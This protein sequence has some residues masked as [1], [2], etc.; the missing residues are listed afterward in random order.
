MGCTNYPVL[1]EGFCFCRVYWGLTRRIGPARIPLQPLRKPARTT[2]SCVCRPGSP[3]CPRSIPGF[4]EKSPVFHTNYSQ[5]CSYAKNYGRSGGVFPTYEHSLICTRF[6]YHLGG[7]FA[8]SRGVLPIYLPYYRVIL[9]CGCEVNLKQCFSP[10]EEV[11]CSSGMS[12]PDAGQNGRKSRFVDADGAFL[13]PYP[14][15]PG[16]AP[17]KPS[18]AATV[19]WDRPIPTQ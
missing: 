7:L 12:D 5:T 19:G 18:Q 8:S 15:K 2:T 9:P 13:C 4:G 14:Q 1:Y 6:A 16:T 10:S 11:G 3:F 17:F